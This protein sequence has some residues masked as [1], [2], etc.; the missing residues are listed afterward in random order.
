MVWDN[1]PE[2]KLYG[3]HFNTDDCCT[4]MN[5]MNERL[6]LSYMF[7]DLP[8]I[9]RIPVITMAAT[10]IRIHMDCHLQKVDTSQH[11]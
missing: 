3:S 6:Q 11:N 5:E 9:F 7:G 8:T 10:I 4:T 2:L 1:I